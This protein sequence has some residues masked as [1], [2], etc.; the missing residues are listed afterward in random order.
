MLV[1]KAE[2]IYLEWA[3]ISEGSQNLHY[4]ISDPV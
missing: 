4:T 1:T 3:N 2:E